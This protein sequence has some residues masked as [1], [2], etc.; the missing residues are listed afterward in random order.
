M[1]SN[2]GEP[3]PAQPPKSMEAKSTERAPK[4]R[5]SHPPQKIK[6]TKKTAPEGADF[7]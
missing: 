2:Q 3:T 5:K 1:V 6:R 4:R 7:T